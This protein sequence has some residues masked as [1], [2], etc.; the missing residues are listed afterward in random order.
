M[1]VFRQNTG[2][3][4]IAFAEEFEQYADNY[5]ATLP[6]RL[7]SAAIPVIS[8]LPVQV[9][10]FRGANGGTEVEIHAVAPAF[11]FDSPGGDTYHVGLFLRTNDGSEV[12]R[13]ER[14]AAASSHDL[15]S[16]RV[17]LHDTSNT[18]LAVEEYDSAAHRVAVLRR[19]LVPRAFKAGELQVSDLLIATGIQATTGSPLARTDFDIRVNPAATFDGRD[20]IGVYFELYGLGDAQG[21]GEYEAELVVTITQL[22][23]TGSSIRRA[24]GDLADRW[25]LTQEGKDVAQVTFHKESRTSARAVVPDYFF[26]QLPADPPAGKYALTLTV[27]DRVTGKSVTADREFRISH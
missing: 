3:A 19:E 14:A 21:Y 5:R 12:L 26:V 22:E 11:A 20:K 18:W 6:A 23:R 1:F 10:Q 8:P 15:V 17:A 9:A 27:R 24:L 13:H 25:G 16:W 7:V 2:F 4:H